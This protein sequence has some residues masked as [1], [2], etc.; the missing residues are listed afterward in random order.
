MFVKLGDLYFKKFMDSQIRIKDHFK[1]VR[2]KTPAT[3]NKEY[4]E[5]GTI[6]WIN[7]GVLTNLYFLT[8]KISARKLISQKAIKECSLNFTK[9]NSVLI[10]R[11][12]LDPSKVVFC[13]V[14]DITIGDS[15]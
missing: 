11:H 9:K 12:Q 8:D 13:Q 15:V 2:G 7:S 14:D 10:T 1:L 3:N 6:K 4:Y 5:N